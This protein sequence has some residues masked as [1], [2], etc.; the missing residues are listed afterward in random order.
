MISPA[1]GRSARPTPCSE[2]AILAKPWVCDTLAANP[3]FDRLIP[4]DSE[5][6]H[7]G[8]SGRLRLVR[9]LRRQRFTLA[10]SSRRR[11]MPRFPL[12]RPESPAHRTGHGSPRFPLDR[13]RT[14]HE[15]HAATASHNDVF[16]DVARAAGCHPTSS[17]PFFS[18]SGQDRAFARPFSEAGA[19]SCH[20]SGGSR[21][22]APGTR[23]GLRSSRHASIASAGWSPLS[24]AMAAT[25]PT[26]APG[27]PPPFLKRSSRPA[28]QPSDRWCADRTGQVVRG[29]R[30]RPMHIAGALGTATVG[31]FGPALQKKPHRVAQACGSK[32]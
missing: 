8:I 25:R 7:K 2:I 5:G 1:T 29:K 31:I 14:L 4:Y 24:S 16:L 10:F 13:A 30:F 3:F 17:L 6:L 27:S 11:S 12:L 26:P 20:P 18:L 19:T 21:L 28:R 9:E 22:R 15:G 32:P 23:R